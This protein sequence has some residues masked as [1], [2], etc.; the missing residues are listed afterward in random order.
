MIHPTSQSRNRLVRLALAGSTGVLLFLSFP[1]FGSGLLAWVALAPLLLALRSANPAEGFRIGFFSGL[2]AHVG[3]LYWIVH[4]VV[5]YGYLPLSAGLLA[6]LLLC[7]YLSLY[8]AAFSMGVAWF[9][10]RGVHPFWSAP[11]LWTVLE[12]IRSHLLTGFPW[13]NLAYSQYLHGNLIQI[14]DLTGIYGI[15]FAIVLANAL[16]CDCFAERDRKRLLLAEGLAVIAVIAA[17]YGYGHFRIANLRD[18]LRGAAGFPVTLVQGN[19]DQSVKWD[20]RYQE[21]TLEVYRSLTLGEKTGEG[22]L[23]VW[24]ETAAPFHFQQPGPMREKVAA[25]AETS[26]SELLFGSPSYEE[27]NGRIE[28]M[29]SAFLLR[30]DGAAAGRY[31]KVHLVP[32]GEY[33]PLRKI[34]PFIGKLVVGVGDFRP[35]EGFHPIR[36][37]GRSLGVLICYEG[38]FPEGARAY[39]REGATLLVNITNDAWFGS[40][41]APHQHLSMT[42][43][44]AVETRLYLVRA[45]NTGI[46]A[47]I[48]P[49]GKILS[50]TP[51]F[52]RT[53]LKGEVKII[54]EKTFYAAYGDLFVGLC[55]I[56]LLILWISTSLR[57]RG[58]NDVRRN[59]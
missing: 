30:P 43:F 34:F 32:Y 13:E 25:V 19:I 15:S 44:R 14:A 54:D 39:K 31:D 16:L 18:A 35:G 8:T 37:K 26:G 5:H 3:I 47:I 36:G 21:E 22:G 46:S 23:I 56:V 9:R 59:S 28:Y 27:A 6:M 11:L 7:A 12:F 53:V 48:D 57:Q 51:L 50:R 55:G 33:V 42:V 52:E 49:S 38:I 4:V 10:G 1:K 17:M 40:T 45:A 41:S 29:N 58:K 2:V 20:P 24:P